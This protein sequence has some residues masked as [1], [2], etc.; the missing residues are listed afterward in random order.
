MDGFEATRL[1]RVSAE[2][3]ATIPIVALTA[4]ALAQ[5]REKCLKSG[6]DDFLCK[7]IRKSDLKKSLQ[8]WLPSD[9]PIDLNAAA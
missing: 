5:D 8:R 1:I 3:T 2:K 9:L 6:M 4:S 7:P